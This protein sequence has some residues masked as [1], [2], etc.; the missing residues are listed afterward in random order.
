M[1]H[2]ELGAA[3]TEHLPALRRAVE[4]HRKATIRYHAGSDEQATTRTICPYAL[5]FS[6]GMWY[7]AAL[8][9]RSEGLRFFRLD[10]I[11]MV[12]PTDSAFALPDDVSVDAFVREKVLAHAGTETMTVRY[13]ASIA[14]WIAE[15]EGV[16]PAADGSLTLEHPLADRGWAIRHVLQY[17]PDAEVLEPAELREA[18]VERL[19][20]VV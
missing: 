2:A 17:G 1:H 20:E 11:E 4:A 7:V 5:V 12:E 8:C 15:R 6:H 9:E 19:R 16:I 14:R 3:G 10:R 13:S 18:I